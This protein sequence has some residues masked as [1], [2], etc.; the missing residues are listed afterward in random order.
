MADVK[1]APDGGPVSSIR[2]NPVRFET[3]RVIEKKTSTSAVIRKLDY[4][5]RI[6]KL[7]DATERVRVEKKIEDEDFGSETEDELLTM[8]VEAL[9]AKPEWDHVPNKVEVRAKPDIVAAIL[10]VRADKES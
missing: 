5:A 9:K 3:V 6:H 8:T 2:M 1:K 10:K 7:A 4:D